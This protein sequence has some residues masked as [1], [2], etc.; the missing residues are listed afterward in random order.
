MI[1]TD[2]YCCVSNRY[3]G[4]KFVTAMQDEHRKSHGMTYKS[5]RDQM[6]QNNMVMGFDLGDNIEQ[7]VIRIDKIQQS[8]KSIEIQTVRLE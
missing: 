6:K 2:V 7:R 8:M 1:V 5:A 4:T 3:L